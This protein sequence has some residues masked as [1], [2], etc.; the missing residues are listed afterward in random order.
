MRARDALGDSGQGTIGLSVVIEAAFRR[1]DDMGAASPFAHQPCAGAH[2][3]AVVGGDPTGLGEGLG[4][5]PKP[6]PRRLGEPSVDL[7]LELIGDSAH[8]Q[9]TAESPGRGRP[10]MAPP[11]IAQRRRVHLLDLGHPGLDRR[12]LVA[13][14]GQA[15]HR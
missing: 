10:V 13:P 3:G 1:G 5:D 2:L 15:R 9:V 14:S 12:H 11:C 8:Q 7:F 4:Q 6:P